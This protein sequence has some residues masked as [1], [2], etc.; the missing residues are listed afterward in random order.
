MQRVVAFHSNQL[1]WRGTEVSLYD[2][3]LH[4]ETLLGNRSLIVSQAH[5]DLAALAKFTAR[6]PVVLYREVAELPELLRPHGVDTVYWQ[7]AGEADG[8]LVPGVRNVVH[9]VFRNREPH[10]DVY[11]YISPWLSEVCTGGTAP[12]VP[13]MVALPPGGHGDLRERLGIPRDAV[14]FGRHGG[15]GQFDIREAREAVLD[16]ARRRPERWFVFLNTREF[17]PHPANVVFLPPTFDL[18]EKVRFL[19]TCDYMLHARAEGETFGLAVAEFL[20]RGKPVLT[21]RYGYDQMHLRVLGDTALLYDS[22]ASLVRLLE[23]LARGADP[24]PCRA[25]VR[26]YAPEPVMERFA[27]VFL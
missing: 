23:T 4:N 21:C 24:E 18:V 15:A 17:G 19:D 3:A 7:K 5:A 1:S 13:Y 25:R 20:L 9:V 22:A 12:W 11:A 8:R 14:V 27:R 6:F 16:V 26:A 2:Y 10:G